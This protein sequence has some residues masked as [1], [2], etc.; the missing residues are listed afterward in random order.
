L[1]GHGDAFIMRDPS[2][3]RPAFYYYDDEV[4]VATSERPVIQTTFN[5]PYESVKEL[6]PGYA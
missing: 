4:V 1:L 3:I 2:G 5:V 6:K